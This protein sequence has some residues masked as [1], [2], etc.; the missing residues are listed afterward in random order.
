MPVWE[1]WK[2]NPLFPY[3]LLSSYYCTC[4]ALSVCL[5]SPQAYLPLTSYGLPFSL[6]SNTHSPSSSL[7]GTPNSEHSLCTPTNESS[8]LTPDPPCCW[9]KYSAPHSSHMGGGGWGCAHTYCCSPRLYHF[10]RG[11]KFPLCLSS[12]W[13]WLPLCLLFSIP[14]YLLW[15]L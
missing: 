14:L 11:W 4:T 1:R 2:L 10:V 8:H 15:S 9:I 13:A 3:S 5:S 6:S 7:C 12:T